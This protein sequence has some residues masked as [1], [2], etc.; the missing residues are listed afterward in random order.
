M[1]GRHTFEGDVCVLRVL[2]EVTEVI[3][4]DGVAVSFGAASER[5]CERDRSLCLGCFE[6]DGLVL[7]E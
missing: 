5:V 6:G 4:E 7:L 3:I 2:E 1:N